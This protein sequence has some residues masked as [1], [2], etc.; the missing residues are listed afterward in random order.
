[1]SEKIV[2]FKSDGREVVGMFHI[3]DRPVRQ[4]KIGIVMVNCWVKYR[5]GPHRMFVQAARRWSREGFYVLRVDF[6][7]MGDSEGEGQYTHMDAYP[8][9]TSLDAMRF[10]KEKEE[11]QEV[12]LFGMCSGARNVLYAAEASPEV[13][14]LALLSLPFKASP[15]SSTAR[16]QQISPALTKGIL[17]EYYHKRLG[18]PD[19]WRRLLTGQSDYGFMGGLMRF[20]VCYLLGLEKKKFYQGRV[21]LSLR[22]F[23][24]R[25]GRAF[26]LFGGNDLVLNDFRDNFPMITKTI[27]EIESLLDIVIVEGANHT[28]DR[29]AWKMDAIEH[30]TGW[31]N[32]QFPM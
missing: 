6:P 32:R 29:V 18:D 11:V 23:F 19:A 10:L 26:F 30:V 31:L 27:R 3:P 22:E 17:T 13:R 12:V 20:F 25:Q 9:C 4:S 2:R 7:G 21:Y 15:Y 5:V 1:M 14:Y 28:F 8:V 16:F 24:V